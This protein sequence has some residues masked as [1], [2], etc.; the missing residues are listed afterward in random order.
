VVLLLNLDRPLPPLLSFL[1][2]FSVNMARISPAD[3]RLRGRP[4]GYITQNPSSWVLIM[5]DDKTR[6]IKYFQKKIYGSEEI[7]AALLK[8][9]RRLSDLLGKTRNKCKVTEEGDIEMELG[10]GYKMLF[11]AESLD[12]VIPHVWV[13]KACPMARINGK[14]VAFHRYVMDAEP[15]DIVD[16]ISADIFDNRLVNLSITTHA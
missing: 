2:L 7:P 14:Y 11:S 6:D 10:G 3:V 9:R 16:H 12:K 15:G 13:Q 1:S 8:E 5:H 4:S